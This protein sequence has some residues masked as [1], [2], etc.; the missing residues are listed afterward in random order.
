[1]IDEL[2]EKHVD[3][4]SKLNVRVTKNSNDGSFFHINVRPVHRYGYAGDTI[5][6]LDHFMKLLKHVDTRIIEGYK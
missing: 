1:M 2:F 6:G 4:I 3:K 5:Q